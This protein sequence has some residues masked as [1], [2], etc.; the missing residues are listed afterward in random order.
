MVADPNASATHC[1]EYYC[2]REC[3]SGFKPMH[4]T[5]VFCQK[6]DDSPA[7]WASKQGPA[8]LGGC[9]RIEHEKVETNSGT[10]HRLGIQRRRTWSTDRYSA[11]LIS[12]DP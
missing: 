12:E 11:Q 2:I 9:E 5:K 1:D 3:K 7:N 8:T 4:P 10:I 6:K